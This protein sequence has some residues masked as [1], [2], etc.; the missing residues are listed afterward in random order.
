MPASA[1]TFQ[2]VLLGRRLR[3]A[4]CRDSANPGGEPL[5]SYQD[6]PDD[7]AHELMAHPCCCV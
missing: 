3:L 7:V 4:G 2:L 6:A 1:W 5:H